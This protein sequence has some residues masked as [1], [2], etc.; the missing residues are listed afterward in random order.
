M[1][2]RR[3]FAY[4]FAVFSIVFWVTPKIQKKSNAMFDEKAIKLLAGI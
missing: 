1:V 4:C 2:A 3:A